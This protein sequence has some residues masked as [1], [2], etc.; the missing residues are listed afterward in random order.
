M[1]AGR[2]AVVPARAVLARATA[3]AE[4]DGHENRGFLSETHGFLPR[5]APRRA[6]PPSHRAWDDTAAQLP[7]LFRHLTLRATFDTLPVLPATGAALP[8][9]ALLRAAAV[10]GISAHAYF[11]ADP[12]PPD[13]LPASITRPWQEVSDR[14]DR[15]GPNL[16][17]IDLNAYNW[18]LRP[19]R[20]DDGLRVENLALLI[21]ILGNEDERRFQM[22]PVEMLALFTPIVG[23][24]V[25]A[26]EAVA[27]ADARAL[28]R[29]LLM[30]AD[31]VEELTRSFAKVDPNPH[32]PR[33]VNP[34][35]WGKT[36]APLA[37]PFQA[38]DPP[39]GPSGTAIPAFQLLDIVFGRH[40]HAT[41]IGKETAVARQWF[42]AHWREFL[43]AAE[44][45]SI[46]AFVAS[47]GDRALRGV[48][49]EA[50]EA[51]AGGDGLL[52]RHRLKTFG[53]LDLSFKAGRSKTLGGFAGSFE[54][55]PWDR[56]DAELA[57][58][59]LE[60]VP[61]ASPPVHHAR[62]ARVEELHAANDRWVGEVVLDLEGAGVRYRPGSRCAVL[63]EQSPE[64]VA[65]TLAALHARGDEPVRLD[66]A[67][68]AAVGQRD[69]YEAARVL[70]LRDLLT[71]GQLRP[72]RRDVAKALYA[73][74]R[75]ETLHRIIEARAED[76][77]ELCEVLELLEE[78]SGL[79]PAS[80]WK[81]HPA[82]GGSICAI[83]PPESPRMYSI[84]SAMPAGG[85]A[86]GQ[87][88]LT[89]GLLRYTT[90]AS[91][92]SP[93]GVRQ[94]TA[95]GY[96]AR[97]AGVKADRGVSVR[98]VAPAGFE[99]PQDPRAPVVFI[100]GGTGISPFLGMIAARASQP[101]AGETWLYLATRTSAEVYGEQQLR[102]HVAAGALHLRIALSQEDRRGASDG[103]ALVWSPA[104][105]RPIGALL[106]EDAEAGRLEKLL[107]PESE[108]GPGGH[109]YVCGRAGFAAAVEE[110]L[111]AVAAR[112]LSGSPAQRQAEAREALS[113][114]NGEGRYAREVY[115]TYPGPH[116]AAGRTYD[117]S[118]VVV[119]NDPGRSCWMV[120]EGRVYDLTR[121][122][123]LHPGGDKILRSYAGMD[124][125]QAYRTVGHDAHPEVHALLG[126]YEC[127]TVRRLDFGSAWSTAIGPSGLR[128]VTVKDAF[129]T[130]IRLLFRVVEIENAMAN[131]YGVR[132]EPVTHDERPG[133]VAMSPYK[134]RALFET[135]RRF[136]GEHL[137]GVTGQRLADLW[138]V[139]SGLHGQR[140]DV[141]WMQ[142]QMAE[143][144]DGQAAA[145]AAALDRAVTQAFGR[146][147]RTDAAAAEL[148]WC[149]A[150]VTAVEAEDRRV[151]SA[152][153]E[154]LRDGVRVFER[155]EAETVSAGSGDLLAAAVSLPDILR[156][157]LTRLAALLP[158]AGGAARP[159]T[160]EGR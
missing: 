92:V 60:R 42:P 65:R 97:R 131:D 10:L 13:E 78:E 101:D 2:P 127:G 125:T 37:T 57:L 16:S 81:S 33:Y 145:G 38:V 55:R 75:N 72:V 6:L 44:A 149:E 21:P 110:S 79:R 86:A 100:A 85:E 56:M 84:S 146:M 108:G 94:G 130:W 5:E 152:L 148:G 155:H 40:A 22:T 128:L 99:L 54:D 59:R 48:F 58:A 119:R 153:K 132:D 121:F 141:R 76:Q 47:H 93:P 50:R 32:S 41:T 87:V 64:L 20:A 103:G 46:P 18:R 66:A 137:P 28:K 134:A 73:L 12:D 158:S 143:I 51:Y 104:P 17:F 71:F 23:A 1:T 69:G 31:T 157:S 124:A 123:H 147:G 67:W 140:H 61:T 154:A 107:R 116:F 26:Q 122:A 45:I 115:T 30:I 27:G 129:R 89:V 102:R 43:S 105:R 117:A 19:G 29:E 113:R 135:H 39:P 52:G 80:L 36:V 133:A 136:R 106:A 24:S 90:P 160:R 74:T 120:V 77:W 156:S 53:F 91:D 70:P 96:L 11:Y 142:Q 126:L 49:A 63:P 159:D 88:R 109:V 95:S 68:L 151:V 8:D 114:L 35:V 82:Q 25:R 3:R 15:P 112:F 111:Q 98:I 138:A 62:L 150:I 4:R 9:D 144:A 34:V 14:L 7:E 118:E 83:V 139:T